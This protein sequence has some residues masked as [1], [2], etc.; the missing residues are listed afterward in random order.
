MAWYAVGIAAIFAV[1]AVLSLVIRGTGG[2][3]ADDAAQEA[4][5]AAS[6]TV[7]PDPRESPATTVDPDNPGAVP[8]DRVAY[9]TA[10]GR[11]L[12]GI[13]ANKPVEVATGAAIGPSGLGSLA[14]SPTGDLIAFVRNDGSVVT[15]PVEGGEQRILATDASKIS[16]GDSPSLVWNSTSSQIAYRAVGTEAMVAERPTEQPPLSGPGAFR[17]PLPTGYLGD[18]VRI[19]DREGK[20]IQR[21]GDPSTRSVS[22][23]ATSSTDDFLLLETTIPGTSNPYTLSTASSGSDQISPTQF[24]ADDP[25]FSPDGNFIV[26]VAPVG[27]R[28]EL[29]RISAVT[30]LRNVLTTDEAICAP[31]VSPDGTRIVY[32]AG[33]DCSKLML[34]S[35]KGGKPKEISPPARP[36]TP[37]FRSGRVAWT[38]DGHFIAFS[39]C[40][41]T[42]GPTRCSGD[43]SFFDP[44]RGLLIPGPTATTVATVNRPLLADVKVSLALRGPVEYSGTF[45][46]DAK[47][48]ADLGD[49]KDGSGTVDAALVDGDRSLRL[50]L[51]IE[52]GSQFG[53]GTM[54]I[55]DPD[56]GIDRT[57]TVTGSASLLGVRM[58][59]LSGIWISTDDLPFMSGEFKLSLGRDS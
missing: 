9:V 15:V 18:V 43:I 35:A 6:T 21:I 57:F 36:G 49:F 50:K 54:S 25:A 16:I 17:V 13:G 38:Q 46:V 51:K 48:E 40:R 26:A 55:V 22:G 30:F 19:V 11:V 52:E 1:V 4:A 32:S 28:Q 44:D 58:A 59:N 20:A 2:R 27:T 8:T 34:I 33:K 47:S 37:T 29:A 39:D 12:S 45:P 53:A 41:I 7:A 42:D 10:D 23:I 56:K 14:V 3:T 31:V 24:S 5:A